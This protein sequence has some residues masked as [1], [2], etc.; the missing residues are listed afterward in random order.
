MKKLSAS[1]LV[2][3]FSINLSYSQSG[4]AR[5]DWYFGMLGSNIGTAGII[6]TDLDGNGLND[7]ISN[8][9]YSTDFWS[10]S[11]F[12]T[13]T[14]YS[15]KDNTYRTKWISRLYLHKLTKIQVFDFNKDGTKEI[16][17]G[18]D[19]GSIKVFDGITFSE[20]K[21]FYI[22]KR[23]PSYSV[24]NQIDDLQFGDADNDSNIDLVA[25][26]GDT[27]YIYNESYTLKAKIL[28]GAKYFAIGD[29]DNDHSNEIV[30][31]NGK[32]FQNVNGNNMFKFQFYTYNK[33]S[34]VA[35]S[36]INFDGT[37]DLIYTSQDT[38]IAYDFKNKKNIW[39]VKTNSNYDQFI[40]GLW[41][42]DYD[43]DA[44]DDI[45]VGNISRYGIDCYNGRGGLAAF[46]LSNINGVTNAG[47]ADL[48][49]DQDLDLICS[50]G[51]NNTGPDY[52]YVYDLNSRTRSWQSTHYEGG[53]TAFDVGD[54][55]N[56]QKNEL[57]IGN[58]GYKNTYYEYSLMLSLNAQDHSLLW[59]NENPD[60]LRVDNISSVKIGDINN[61][62]KNQLLI[63]IDNR[64]EFTYVYALDS[65]YAI[66]RR[67]EMW[68]MDMVIDMK[69]ADID[70]DNENELVVTLGT[71][72]TASSTPSFFQNY[73]YIFNA[74]T[75]EEKWK[76]KQLGGMRS[77]I[78]SLC[79]SNIDNDDALEIV[80]LKS[81]Y[82]SDSSNLYIIDGKTYD[83]IE[84]KATK[85]KAVDVQDVDGDGSQEIIIGMNNGEI[86]VL[87]GISLNE[88][89]H[90][91]TD[92][93]MISALKAYDLDNDNT[94]EL[95]FTDN[96]TLRIY[97]MKDAVTQ[98]E[99]DTLGYSVGLL[100][101]LKIGDFNSDGYPEV[102]L[103]VNHALIQFKIDYNPMHT[104]LQPVE[105][106]SKN[107]LFQNYP[108]PFS[109]ETTIDFELEK[110]SAVQIKIYNSLGAEMF[111][112]GYHT[113]N[114]GLNSIKINADNLPEG[115]YN[116]VLIIDNDKRYSKKMV[117]IK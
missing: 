30:Y 53:F 80:A 3:L 28:F 22:S 35:L 91:K 102:L 85:Y 101:S 78:G 57:A 4:I 34:P 6:V 38:L 64:Y 24:P 33:Q 113:L 81:V 65:N 49:G 47:I 14:E 105:G 89:L 18:F 60:L 31:S 46:S 17:A 9:M 50:T 99:S 55:K 110:K 112:R 79:I 73:I 43:D 23:I 77:K 48:D 19:D 12:I 71:D 56:D 45:F 86:S 25:T 84:K 115:I 59:Q 1:I 76:S 70:L 108:N 63:G 107:I 117:V 21:T 69:I 67:F 44:I 7:I 16:Y 42:S 41:L 11:S 39:S 103:N 32:I 88:K 92:C 15:A 114:S 72:V 116:Y 106:Q 2:L 111:S 20:I 58:T 74:K 10:P 98:W 68:G 37:K 100:N 8:G 87:D 5:P 93:K 36:D 61:D 90:I 83:L 27:T 94:K 13:I 26:N 54:L 95:V 66:Q 51:A 109:A 75:G 52:F 96:Y 104:S 40:T 97:S 29:I 62:G 82:N